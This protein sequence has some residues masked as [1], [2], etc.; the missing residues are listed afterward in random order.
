MRRS[1]TWQKKN[2][3]ALLVRGGRMP[4]QGLLVLASAAVVLG[5]CWGAGLSPHTARAQDF[6]QI[7]VKVTRLGEHLR[8][9]RDDTDAVLSQHGQDRRG[10]HGASWWSGVLTGATLLYRTP[11]PL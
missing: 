6:D 5:L 1:A 8:D 3:H 7:E 4:P 10:L 9:G 11:R 2:L